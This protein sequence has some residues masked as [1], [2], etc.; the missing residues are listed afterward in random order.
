MAAKQ[1]TKVTG[2]HIK[3][4]LDDW[5][6]FLRRLK[7]SFYDGEAGTSGDCDDFCEDS[8]SPH[9][10]CDFAFGGS[11]ECGAV[12]EDGEIVLEV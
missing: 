7:A 4:D 8:C 6:E 11:G 2:N 12:C 1:I 10:G 5:R 9:G 3:I